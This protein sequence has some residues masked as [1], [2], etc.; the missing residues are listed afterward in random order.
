MTGFRQVLEAMM[1]GE[2]RAQFQALRDAPPA[3]G[4]VGAGPRGV[5]LHGDAQLLGAPGQ[6]QH[7][8]R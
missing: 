8:Q 1:D 3:P 4:E 7:R 6:P 2:T 5:E